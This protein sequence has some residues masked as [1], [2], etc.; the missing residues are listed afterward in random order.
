MEINTK[1]DLKEASEINYQRIINI[2]SGLSS[3]KLSTTFDFYND[4]TK[5]DGHW[6]R[7]KNVMDVLTHLH[8]W[9]ELV[10]NWIPANLKGIKQSFIP[11]PYS[12]ETYAD[13][14]QMFWNKHQND[15]L[16]EALEMFKKSHYEVMDLLDTFTEEQLFTQGYYPWDEGENLASYFINNTSSHYDWAIDKLLAH[17]N[18]CLK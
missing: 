4:K 7:D 14:N 17:K 15:S 8:E 9:H 6:K 12:W 1:R 5:Q 2:V 16:A 13:M 10:L 18:N 11:K 3:K